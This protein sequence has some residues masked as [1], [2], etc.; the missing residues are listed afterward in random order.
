MDTESP[1]RN[2]E[3]SKQQ[4]LERQKLLCPFIHFFIFLWLVIFTCYSLSLPFHCIF[5]L[6]PSISVSISFICHSAPLSFLCL[7]PLIP[8]SLWTLV[9]FLTTTQS[10]HISFH[11]VHNSLGPVAIYL[12]TLLIHSLLPGSVFVFLD[13]Q[14]NSSLQSKPC[15]LCVIGQTVIRTS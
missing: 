1:F 10:L 9:Q 15:K 2:P 14:S 6:S 8:F 13:K 12:P 11:V 3:I 4:E 5:F 7:L